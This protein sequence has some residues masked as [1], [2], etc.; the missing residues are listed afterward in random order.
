MSKKKIIIGIVSIV[1]LT[2]I[3]YAITLYS[4]IASLGYVLKNFETIP[5]P[6]TII[7]EV[8][9]IIGNILSIP[10]I[11]IFKNVFIESTILEH[12]IF[13]GNSA[14]W[15]TTVYLII[16]LIFRVIKKIKKER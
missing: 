1:I 3:F 9:K 15:A 5:V 11:I 10:M 8:L 7:T 6:D 12:L 13:I 16:Q 14:L 4:L 2:G